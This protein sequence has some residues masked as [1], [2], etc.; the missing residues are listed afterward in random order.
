MKKANFYLET[1][2]Q[3]DREGTFVIYPLVRGFG[4]TLGNVLRRI[5]LSSLEGAVI[6]YVR[7]KGVSHPF[8]KVAGLKE[9]VLSLM[10][11]LKQLRFKTED[12]EEKKLVLKK[13]GPGVITGADI[14]DSTL[15]ELVN[16]EVYL[17][18]LAEKGNLEVELTVG[19]G[20]GYELAEDKEE[21]EFGMMPI[22]SIYSPVTNVVFK[23]EPARVGRKTD[24]DK[25]TISVTTDGSIMPEKALRTSAESLIENLSLLRDG[26]VEKPVVEEKTAQENESDNE[27]QDREDMMVDEL[28]L[29]T[30]VINALI[31]HG[32]ETVTQLKEM[33]DE[34]LNQVRG[35]GKKSI[36][37]LK[38][39]VAEI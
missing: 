16:K 21:R 28:D 32:I 12:A 10:L 22:D 4:S 7:I 11:N 13:K 27:K 39:K 26:G 8:S 38:E 9:D 3:T 30:R 25:L 1:I 34:E 33:P 37:E 29:P 5:M 23:V 24:F 20:T 2:S 17:G 19:R 6:K 15:C 35:L 14:E 18:E 36:E 31:K